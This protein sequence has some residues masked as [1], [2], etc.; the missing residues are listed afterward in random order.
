M[1]GHESG[2]SPSGITINYDYFAADAGDDQT[3]AVRSTVNFD[4]SASCAPA[5]RTI[6]AYAWDFGDGTTG[7]GVEVT[8]TYATP[9]VYTVEL[10]VT[11]DQVAPATATAT[12]NLT[13]TAFELVVDSDNTDD[14]LIF[15][16]DPPSD[17]ASGTNG[18]GGTDG[19]SGASGASGA[20]SGSGARSEPGTTTKIDDSAAKRRN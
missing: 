2:W 15:L 18:E 17:S 1:N 8:H 4:G 3:V 14:S 13:L 12:D 6:A 11:D 10:T 20:S 7:S 9:G 16:D 5:G 19:T